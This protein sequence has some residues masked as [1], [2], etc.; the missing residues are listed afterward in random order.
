MLGR[1][2][3]FRRRR[4]TGWESTGRVMKLLRTQSSPARLV[5]NKD[6]HYLRDKSGFLTQVASTLRHTPITTTRLPEDTDTLSS[7]AL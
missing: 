1:V 6:S 5:L 2:L 3:S 4:C 7:T